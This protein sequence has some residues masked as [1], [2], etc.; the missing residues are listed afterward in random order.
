MQVLVFVLLIVS[1]YVWRIPDSQSKSQK[2]Y[3]LGML[4]LILLSA[5][6]LAAGLVIPI[7]PCVDATKPCKTVFTLSGFN[8]CL[9][10]AAAVPDIQNFLTLKNTGTNTDFDFALTDLT[11]VVDRFTLTL[12]QA[13]KSTFLLG[14]NSV[15]EFTPTIF[16]TPTC[17]ATY[18]DIRFSSF[19]TIDVNNVKITFQNPAIPSGYTCF[20]AQETGLVVIN[21]STLYGAGYTILYTSTPVQPNISVSVFTCFNQSFA[22]STR[23]LIA[24]ATVRSLSNPAVCPTC[25]MLVALSL[26]LVDTTNFTANNVLVYLASSNPVDGRIPLQIISIKGDFA[27]LM[28]EFSLSNFQAN[29]QYIFRYTF[30]DVC[31]PALLSYTNSF[32]FG[33][34]NYESTTLS[35]KSFAITPPLL[36]KANAYYKATAEVPN[37]FQFGCIPDLAGGLWVAVAGSPTLF[38][39]T[40]CKALT[41]KADT[42]APSPSPPQFAE[43]WCTYDTKTG[44][45]VVNFSGQYDVV[46]N[47]TKPSPGSYHFAA[48]SFTGCTQLG[49]PTPTYLSVVFQFLDATNL[50]ITSTVPH[51]CTEVAVM[52]VLSLANYDGC[53]PTFSSASSPTSQGLNWTSCLGQTGTLNVRYTIPRID[54]ASVMGADPYTL[55]YTCVGE[56]CNNETLLILGVDITYATSASMLI[57]IAGTNYTLTRVNATVLPNIPNATRFYFSISSTLLP[58]TSNIAARVY[59]DVTTLCG[60]VSSFDISA[61]IHVQIIKTITAV[62]V[63]VPANT[64]YSGVSTTTIVNPSNVGI[65]TTCAADYTVTYTAAT[66][67]ILFTPVAVAAA[68]ECKVTFERIG[69]IPATLDVSV[70]IL[71]VDIMNGV[72][73]LQ[74]NKFNLDSRCSQF[75]TGTLNTNNYGYTLVYGHSYIVRCNLAPEYLYYVS[76]DNVNYNPSTDFY[77]NSSMQ[78]ATATIYIKICTHFK[79]C[80]VKQ[81][82][83]GVVSASVGALDPRTITFSPQQTPVPIDVI[84]LPQCDKYSMSAL[85][86]TQQTFNFAMT[87]PT[88]QP[89]ISFDTFKTKTIQFIF[90]PYVECITDRNTTCFAT[91]FPYSNDTLTLSFLLENQVTLSASDSGRLLTVT[92]TSAEVRTMMVR[93][94]LLNL[95]EVYAQQLAVSAFGSANMQTVLNYAATYLSMSQSDSVPLC[96]NGLFFALVKALSPTLSNAVQLSLNTELMLTDAAGLAYGSVTLIGFQHVVSTTP[97]SWP[98]SASISVNY[99]GTILVYAAKTSYT[100][101]NFVGSTNIPLTF[102]S[103]G[104]LEIAFER[105]TAIVSSPVYYAKVPQTASEIAILFS[106]QSSVPPSIMASL[107]CAYAPFQNFTA[108]YAALSKVKFVIDESVCKTVKTNIS[109]SCLCTPG[110]FYALT[111]PPGLAWPIYGIVL[112]SLLI[113]IILAG[114]ACL[115]YFLVR[116]GRDGTLSCS[117][118]LWR[119]SAWGSSRSK[120]SLAARSAKALLPSGTISSQALHRSETG[121]KK[122]HKQYFV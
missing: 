27:S 43:T 81:M 31:F 72:C 93:D 118:P 42:S 96:M 67:Q 14:S 105:T 56:L 99:R 88:A 49:Q 33:T 108:F 116:M 3:S 28:I 41:F 12:A 121:H 20:S 111:S 61:S 47:F 34:F 117:C 1:F 92:V 113:L 87:S 54:V 62:I 91:T 10:D 25:T 9:K 120:S 59:L 52:S 24:S 38:N 112:M 29:T 18:S 44:I 115:I 70:L 5:V 82:P 7:D 95:N 58:S 90:K 8:P 80:F 4:L 98:G 101:T 119:L 2:F 102:T 100:V 35:V 60:T 107:S 53:F 68:L 114:M 78:S 45:L 63:S 55:S 86:T 106:F 21:P 19:P 46:S 48:G 89:S 76:S 11:R 79:A 66:N 77:L 51:I 71:D 16:T 23:Y 64:V 32:S 110:N 30:A 75:F 85:L 83:S 40:T 73:Q 97:L 122:A 103:D 109:V 13:G 15:F 26:N 50:R 74:A 37:T 39:S 17:A 6:H 65:T 84:Y 22:A 94:L 104:I 57:E 69:Y 36:D